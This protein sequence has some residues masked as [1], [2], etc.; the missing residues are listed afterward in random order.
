MRPISYGSLIYMATQVA[1]G[2]KYLEAHNITHRDLATRNVLVGSSH[3]VKIT[4]AGSCRSLYAGDYYTGETQLSPLPIRWMSWEA[5]FLVG[6]IA[7][8]VEPC[9]ATRVLD[10]GEQRRRS[11]SLISEATGVDRLQPLLN[12]LIRRL[13]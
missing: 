6:V 10:P 7:R 13:Q 5:L 9:I 11:R 8:P 2:M 1:S 12:C 3:A 4:C